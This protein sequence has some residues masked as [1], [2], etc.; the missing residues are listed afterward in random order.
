MHLAIAKIGICNSVII[1]LIKDHV[2]AW[3]RGGR[4]KRGV[5]LLL[6]NC[7]EI[8]FFFPVEM[9]RGEQICCKDTG[10]SY[11]KLRWNKQQ[12]EGVFKQSVSI[13]NGFYYDRTTE[14]C[15]GASQLP[16]AHQAGT[17]KLVIQ[18]VSPQPTTLDIAFQLQKEDLK[19]AFSH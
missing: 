16:Q 13:A 7:T 6:H 14:P 3:R 10:K 4:S 15:P 12:T 5:Y 8:E 1:S 11:G 19:E 2:A 17:A 18:T 9:F